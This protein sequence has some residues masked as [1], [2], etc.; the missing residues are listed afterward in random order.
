[1]SKRWLL[2]ATSIA[3]G[4]AGAPPDRPDETLRAELL[5]LVGKDQRAMA[6]DEANKQR[7]LRNGATRLKAIIERRG[8]PAI[9]EVGK[10]GAQAAWLLAQ[11]AD[12]D[13]PFQEAVL[14]RMEAMA[15]DGEV[16]PD[17]LAYLR[18]RV[19]HA[20]GED[21]I[22]GTQGKCNGDQWTP[23]PIRDLNNVDTRRSQMSLGPLA[24]YVAMAGNRLCALPVPPNESAR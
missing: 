4:C 23:F 17:N 24:D 14:L 8:W 9:S 10:D 5:D 18:D 11:H 12:F 7:V 3:I 13:R 16:N 22:Y 1:M 2:L 6:G 21:Q 20:K 19:A 15:P